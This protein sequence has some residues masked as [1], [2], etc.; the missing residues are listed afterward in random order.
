MYY[1]QF[2]TSFLFAAFILWSPGSL[3]SQTLDEIK[4]ISEEHP[5]QNY[6]SA[7]Q[8]AGIAV[9]VLTGIWKSAGLNLTPRDIRFLPWARG[10]LM[11]KKD[12][13]TCLFAISMTRE[14]KKEFKFV[15]PFMTDVIGV[16]TKK[17]KQIRVKSIAD[18]AA[19][20][21]IDTI[22]SIREDIGGQL[23]REQG[24]PGDKI[25]LVNTLPSLVSM[26][27]IDR[28][29]AVALGYDTIVWEM[30]SRGIDPGQYELI[31][32]FREVDTGFGFHK[33]VAPHIITRLQSALNQMKSEGKVTAIINKYRR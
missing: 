32:T 16:I 26:V 10:Y 1:P 19:C 15:G 22:G 13:N 20:R 31:Y 33:D 28:L 25:H 17:S 4:W 23:L 30:K 2:L 18:L 11:L 9:E 12:P 21:T 27:E 6:M 29:S 5:P 7:T 24:Y 14:R 3:K 8:P